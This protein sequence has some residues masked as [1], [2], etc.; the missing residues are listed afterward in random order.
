M[1]SG[2][3]IAA[4]VAA[5]ACFILAISLGNWQ[6][7]RG[8]AKLA[9]QAQAEAAERAAPGEI[10]P[11]LSSIEEIAA[12]L[13]RRVR[14]SGVFDNAGTIYLDNRALN[15][16]AGV[17]VLTPLVIGQQLPALLID[18]GWKPRDPQD[19]SRVSVPAPPPGVVAVEGLAVA[20]PSLLLELGRDAE[21]RVPG[22]WQ[23]L[24]YEAYERV[25]GRRVARF[26]VRQSTDA[27]IQTP[28][29]LQRAWPRPGSG[30]E[31]HRGYAFQWYSLAA[32]I[33][34]LA[35]ALGIK[36]KRNR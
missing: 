8:D 35:V 3:L 1:Q 7:R 9:L 18:R 12:A 4:W 15:G 21:L 34:V 36:R 19:R 11:L 17:Y 13:P 6:M 28:D 23:N 22:L 25:T 26:V 33:A 16:M 27:R 5:V 20:R 2:R 32:L 24:D 10:T 29:G 30:V 14:A 31:K